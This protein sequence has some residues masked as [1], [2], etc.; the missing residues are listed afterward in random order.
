LAMHLGRYAVSQ[1][2]GLPRPWSNRIRI[3]T[4]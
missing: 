2:L 4:D 1:Q 3:F